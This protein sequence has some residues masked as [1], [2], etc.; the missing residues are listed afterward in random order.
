MPSTLELLNTVKLWAALPD[1]Q[2][3]FTDTQLLSIM[4]D[5]MHS[6]VVP[7]IIEYREDFLIKHIDFEIISTKSEYIIPERAVGSVLKD[8]K[9]VDPLD[10]KL[11]IELP[12][13]DFGQIGI[14]S[15]GRQNL[16]FYMRDNWVNI[17]EP[18]R[19]INNKLRMYFYIR[20]NDLVID[21]STK[22][23]AISAINTGT[24]TV[25]MGIGTLP[26]AWIAGYKL[27]FIQSNSPYTILDFDAEIS[28]INSLD[29]T[30]DSLPPDL[31]VGDTLM[32]AKTSL[33]P[34]IPEE[35]HLVL[36]QSAI[37]RVMDVLGDEKG[38]VRAEKKYAGMDYLYQNIATPRVKSEVATINNTEGWL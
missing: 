8:V 27:D 4:T 13:V 23:G 14:G 5:E 32:D 2:P 31:Q 33:Y 21:D 10:E 12:K 20:P 16:G 19:W 18:D 34:S 7:K 26:A 3:A 29:V 28:S 24:N 37:I 17:F 15:V 11:L 36:I 25:T 1:G 6:V 9:M 22:G 38:L 35:L 30:F